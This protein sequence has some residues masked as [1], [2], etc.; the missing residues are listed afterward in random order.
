MSSIEA[1]HPAVVIGRRFLEAIYEGD[2][3]LIWALFSS[4]ARQF[5]VSRGVRRG[6]PA[7]LG[8]EILRDTAGDLEK[9]EF[10]GDLLA[11]IEKDLETVDLGRVVVS[12]EVE[13]EEGSRARLRY[14]ERFVIESGPKL[15]PLPV[16]SMEL[17][18]EE[19]G[20]RIDR[21]HPRPG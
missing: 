16:G 15:D 13:Q 9:A 19:G 7:G 18:L 2:S 14:E 5:V 17:V 6:L 11:G 4:S 12:D 3:E 8:E 10:L 20:W 1:G 21:L